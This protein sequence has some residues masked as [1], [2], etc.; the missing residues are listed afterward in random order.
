MNKNKY[1]CSQ[2]INYLNMYDD[3]YRFL[4]S[5]MDDFTIK[6]KSENT[7]AFEYKKLNYLFVYYEDDPYYIRLI[8]PN[9]VNENDFNNGNLIDIVNNYNATYKAVKSTIVDNNLWF[10]IE[11][12][13][14]SKENINVLFLRIITILETVISKFRTDYLQ[15]K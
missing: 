13:I 9:V 12:F 6:S 2:Q 4:I 3:F 10:S 1:F 15:T 8:L 14:Y 5:Q 11:H 7:I